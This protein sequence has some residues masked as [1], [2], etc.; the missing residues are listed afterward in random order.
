MNFKNILRSPNVRNCWS[1]W[2]ESF[3][4]IPLFKDDDSLIINGI[5]GPEPLRN[6]PITYINQDDDYSNLNF[7]RYG[8][9]NGAF[10]GDSFVVIGSFFNHIYAKMIANFL[11]SELTN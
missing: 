11:K 9:Q 6:Q 5:Q 10:I 8:N 2:I 4:Q 1:I 3:N 7:P